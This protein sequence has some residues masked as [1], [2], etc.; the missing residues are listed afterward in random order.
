MKG[1]MA[2]P[3]QR[4]ENMRLINKADLYRRTNREIAGMKE[5]IRK[6]IGN[7]DRQRRKAYSALADIRTVQGS[8]KIL[9]PNL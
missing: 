9:R 8:R 5:E 1:S 2:E 4:E 7:C 3:Q 6:E